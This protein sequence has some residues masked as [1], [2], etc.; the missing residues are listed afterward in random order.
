MGV[1]KIATEKN[2]DDLKSALKDTIKESM[3]KDKV[4]SDLMLIINYLETK[5]G[6]YKGFE[7]AD[8]SV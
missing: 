8:E 4:I 3:E 1:K 5:L 2:L 7:D 6:I